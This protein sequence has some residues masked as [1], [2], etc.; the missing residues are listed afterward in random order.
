MLI[1]QAV[2]GVRVRSNHRGVEKRG[3]K[4][5]NFPLPFGVRANVQ[6]LPSPP[7]ISLFQACSCTGIVIG[8]LVLSQRSFVGEKGE[9]DPNVISR[10]R[11]PKDDQGQD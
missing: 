8:I 10:R 1:G 5:S 6:V 3:L 11:K 2:Y 9:R 4:E 7:A